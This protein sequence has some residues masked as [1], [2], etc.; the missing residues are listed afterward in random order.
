[1]EDIVYTVLYT[2]IIMLTIVYMWHKLIKRK[3][4]FKNYK[5]YV[6]LIGLTVTAII[7]Y[8]VANKFIKIFIVT[9][10][11]IIFFKYLFNEGTQK[12]IITPIFGQFI[13][14]VSETIFALIITLI[15]NYDGATMVSTCLGTFTTNVSIAFI[16]VIIIQFKFVDKFYDTAI[17]LTDKLKSFQLILPCLIVIV[18]SNVLAMTAYY[19]I[20][21]KYLLIFSVIMTFTCTLI[22]VYSFKTKSNYN[23]VYD[24]YNIAIN[25]LKDYEEMMT[26]Y[27]ID[28]HENKN[29]L[30]TIRA[31]ILSKQKDIPK[32]ID[33]IV[34]EKYE[35]NEK[36]LF[37]MS[38]IPSGG[39][40]ATIYSEILKIKKNKIDYVLD[41]DRKL[42]TV[43]L[44]ELDP[45]IIL[46][47]C[48]IIGVFI[49]N[50]IEEVRSLRIRNIRI[51][52]YVEADNLNIKVSNNYKEKIDVEK[53]FNKGYTTKGTNHGYGLS[54]VK[55]IIDKNPIFENKIEISKE[56]F[57]QIL[58]IKYKKTHCI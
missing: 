36:L 7:N 48:K 3:I 51:Y 18:F 23:K 25:S 46:N 41:F 50:A 35:D 52:L 53:I 29:L 44:I 31:M 11:L 49:D 22:V 47:I 21:F 10:I 12:N 28:N 58:I 2:F 5:L 14:M 39:L 30:L 1:M 4:D 55:S 33:S 15:F 32:Y 54:L 24:K 43:D 27:R 19:K 45:D 17:G 13:M 37:K 20:E 16:S 42:K 6:T 8:I 9:L 40:R 34:E 38:I 57:S 26:K 56:L